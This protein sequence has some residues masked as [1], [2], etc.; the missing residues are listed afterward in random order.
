MPALRG[1][2]FRSS[3]DRQ[4]LAI[5]GDTPYG[6]AQVVSFPNLVAKI[7]ADPDVATVVH[8]GD[9]KNG[10]TPCS[11][12]YFAQ[13]RGYFDSFDDPF[14][15]TPGDNE[16]TDCHRANNGGYNPL[17][18]LAALRALFYPR[19]DTSLGAIQKHLRTQAKERAHREFVEN[20]LWADGH[21]LFSTLHVVGSNN[22]LAPWFGDRP[23]GAETPTERATRLAEV[24]RRTAAALAWL[25][26]TFAKAK[27]E[28][29]HG[30]VLAMQADTWSGPADGFASIIARIAT[31]AADFER[32]VL[33][34]QGDTHRYKVDRPI[35]AAPNVTRVVVEG[36]T[37]SEWLKLTVDPR[38][39]NLFSWERIA[40]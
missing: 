2:P 13:I 16:W 38:A 22:G 6:A 26:E 12:A 21:V 14:I 37:A 36:E 30:V 19:A 3:K 39:P 1:D 32:P 20:R 35:P 29:A 18:R 25:D 4:T 5:I 28:Q 24:E 23:T 10:S 11:D 8:L 27:R 7:D 9:I 15:L 33:L 34:L 17:E 40:A 31:L